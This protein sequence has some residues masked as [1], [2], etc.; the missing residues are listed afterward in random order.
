MTSDRD[1]FDSLFDEAVAAVRDEPIEPR[2]VDAALARVARRLE[3]DL[4]SPASL[5][6]DTGRED[7]AE[8]RIHG[9]EGFRG[10]VP[11]Y[12]AGALSEP[13]RILFEDHTREC[14]PCRRALADAR[15]GE[16]AAAPVVP[17]LAGRS[18]FGRWALAAGLAAAVAAAAL[19]GARL[20]W[21]GP[22]ASA[23]V[24]AI[25]G[26][27]VELDGGALRPLA[28][29]A[30]IERGGRLRTGTGSGA[31]LELAD[32]SR[33]E[34]AE[35]SELTLARRADGVVLELAR[36][37]LIVE[38]AEQKRGKLYVRTDD[39]LVSV[40]G[41][42]FS[43]R[44]GVRGSRVSV[45][46]GE[47]R[48][49][50]GAQLAVLEPG[51]QMATRTQLAAVSLS[52]DIDWSRNAA[53]YR[54]RIAALAAL[55]Q[56]LDATFATPAE[57]TST[58]LLDLAPAATGLWV[59]LPNV[60]GQLADAWA[61][62]ERRV[63]ENPTLA[64][65]WQERFAGGQTAL[66]ISEA[67]AELR[68]FGG[69]L[70]D[71]VAIAVA[72]AAAE[73]P[74]P[75]VVAA[76]ADARGF[77]ALLDAQIARVNA[78]AGKTV[79]LRVTDPAAAVATAETLLVWRTP[80]DLL[81]ASPS[82]ALLREL[83]VALRAGAGGFVGSPLHERLAAVYQRGAGWLAGLDA[84]RLLAD[85]TESATVGDE[86]ERSGFADATQFVFESATTDGQ[87]ESRATFAFR[88][89]RRG[90][91]SWLAAPAPAGALDFV[92][93]EAAFAVAGLTKRPEA[94]FDDLF[95]LVAAEEPTGALAKLAEAEAR[96]G[97]SL[98]DD[99][100]AAVG[101]D[102]AF[103][104]D[105]PWLPQPAWKLVVE[106]RDPSR[107][108]YALGRA[109]EVANAEA[110][111][112]GQ[113]GIRFGE[114]EVDGRRYL[115]L[116]STA[117]VDL[118]YLSFEDGYF[119]AAPSRALI[120][121]AIA[122]RAAGSSLVRSR[123]FLDRLPRDAEPNFSALVWQDLASVAGPLAELIGKASGGEGE[124]LVA[125]LGDG[126]PL[127]VV[128]Y[129]E[130]DAVRLV[131]LGANGP[132]GLSFERLLALAGAAGPLEGNADSDGDA[133]APVE[134]TAVRSVETR[135]RRAA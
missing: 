88:G 64:G 36:G 56:E 21:I 27:L 31:V 82:A 87:T 100:A 51:D 7:G 113:P 126:E 19:L 22:D 75:I 20:G 52:D 54:E 112:H 135:V 106:V 6:P 35:R 50:Q 38:A 89:P 62:V 81:A 59:G 68:E 131:A 84:P 95:A 124:E 12:L 118:A 45:L 125:L 11:A 96:L 117:G 116:A 2:T 39:C 127:L 71:E 17:G 33:V 105:G 34:L 13:R 25:D 24:R 76:I 94:M 60:S 119:I 46:D 3:G 102:F 29:G 78:E 129:G 48:V 67:I 41:T 109:V 133:G 44:H 66:E 53:E 80:D 107:L 47:V 104:L 73:H 14:V 123:E 103:A 16:A 101:S 134:T 55:G 49:R 5:A 18:R 77:D 92:S 26:A 8:H 32:G 65:W 57:R 9:C 70:G 114:E 130:S 63:A 97:F 91:A 28:A 93:A 99:L 23:H 98:R 74:S 128:A 122:R 115:H 132:L 30:E 120:V 90:I 1:R 110:E 121:E 61:L 108:E 72:F 69:H 37:A 43:V 86:L 40:V 58:R 4:A 79:L 15:R 83:D 85:A 111:A 42:I 10:L